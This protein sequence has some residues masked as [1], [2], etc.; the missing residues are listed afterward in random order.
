[1][2]RVACGIAAAVWA[3]LPAVAAPPAELHPSILTGRY[4]LEAGVSF[5]AALLHWLDSLTGLSGPGRTG[6]KT[7]DGHRAEFEAR[8]GRPGPTDVEVLRQFAEVRSRAGSAHADR[9]GVT[10]AFFEAPGLPEA[11]ER[12]AAFT[13]PEGVE[14]LARALDRFAERYRTI[15]DDGRVPRGFLQ[16]AAADGRLRRSLARYLGTVAA[17]F[18]AET[19]GV[20]PA[21]LVLVPVPPG[22]GTHAQA[23]GRFLL[24]EIRE[25]EDL[26]D[27]VPP[28]VHENAHYLFHRLEPARRAALESR[29][30]RLGRD[31]VESW[32]LLLEAL[33]TAIAQGVAAE[34]FLAERW[35]ID[36][37]W[38]HRADVDAYAKALYPLVDRAL[39]D[40]QRLDDTLVDRALA[41]RPR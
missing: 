41:L 2:S 10:V 3:A 20:E 28:I 6:G 25:G 19:R 12:S 8:F 16:R 27:Q 9:D 13:S 14:A 18:G 17:F 33:P 36:S 40:R 30:T 38:Y 24:V 29:A 39:A 7:I 32:H 11:L 4:P 35:S 31:G 21:R 26:R 22:H 23:I 34:R 15:W 37:P 5:H 1:V